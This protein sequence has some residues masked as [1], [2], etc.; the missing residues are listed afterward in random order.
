MDNKLIM[1]TSSMNIT[2]LCNKWDVTYRDH[3]HMHM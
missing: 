1:H 2:H 3:M